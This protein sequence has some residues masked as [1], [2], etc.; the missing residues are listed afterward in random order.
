MGNISGLRSRIGKEPGAYSW[1]EG[2]KKS[3]SKRAD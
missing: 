2:K 1:I 3:E